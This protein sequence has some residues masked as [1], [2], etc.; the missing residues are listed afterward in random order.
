MVAVS[1]VASLSGW[2]ICWI[3]PGR[4]RRPTKAL[5]CGAGKVDDHS[6]GVL[7]CGSDPGHNFFLGEFPGRRTNGADD[8]A[9][10]IGA[11]DVQPPPDVADL[12]QPIALEAPQFGTHQT[13]L[14][15]DFSRRKFG[16]DGGSG[17]HRAAL[18]VAEGRSFIS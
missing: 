6:P 18:A 15:P 5:T 4:S 2:A 10:R 14:S 7:L 16:G 13:E 8:F 3:G 11:D 17:V 9:H 12:D 1:A